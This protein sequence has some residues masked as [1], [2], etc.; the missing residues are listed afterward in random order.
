MRRYDAGTGDEFEPGS[1]GQVLRNKLGIVDP[2]RAGLVETELLRSTYVRVLSQ[3][4]RR[5]VLDQ[6]AI[7]DLHREWLSP[8]YDFAGRLRTV[9]VSKGGL[10]FAPAAYLPQ[11]F[12]EIDAMFRRLMPC[13]GFDAARLSR[14]IAESHAELVLLHPFREGNGR[15]S[16]LVADIMAVQ[17]G[18]EPLAWPTDTEVGRDRYY[19]ALRRGFVTDCEPLTALIREALRARSSEAPPP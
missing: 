13:V 17:A 10:L 1:N 8:I 2:Q 16:R 19:A 15:I 5:L 9:N 14:A 7:L 11:G 6:N 4:N 12:A 18:Y 3:V